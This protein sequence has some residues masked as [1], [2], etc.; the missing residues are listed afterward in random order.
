MNGDKAHIFGHH[1]ATV[2]CTPLGPYYLQEGVHTTVFVL[3]Y[4]TW[5]QE[6]LV[7]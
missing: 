6:L 7:W 5:T 3:C 4:I 2:V 1:Y